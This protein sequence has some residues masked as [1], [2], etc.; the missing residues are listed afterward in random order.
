[1]QLLIPVSAFRTF[2]RFSRV[3]AVLMVYGMYFIFDF[4][5]KRGRDLMKMNKVSDLKVRKLNKDKNL[6]FACFMKTL[7]KTRILIGKNNKLKNFKIVWKFKSKAKT[8]QIFHFS[9]FKSKFF[10]NYLYLVHITFKISQVEIKLFFPSTLVLH[11]Q[12]LLKAP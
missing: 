7:C 10:S 6:T 5:V 2:P 3:S 9:V 12:E 8:F 4:A 11:I 1:M